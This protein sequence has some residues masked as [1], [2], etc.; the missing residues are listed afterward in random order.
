M[1]FGIILQIA[2][3]IPNKPIKL[4]IPEIF[5][6]VGQRSICGATDGPYFGLCVT[7]PMGF[8][9]RVVLLT[10]LLLACEY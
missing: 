1:G 9:A 6:L 7:V 8:K 3:A 4:F 2:S 5:F 10:A